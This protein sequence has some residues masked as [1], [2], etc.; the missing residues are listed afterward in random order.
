MDSR[1]NENN[2]NQPSVSGPRPKNCLV[3]FVCDNKKVLIAVLVAVAIYFICCDFGDSDNT[4]F[5]LPGGASNAGPKLTNF[6][7][8]VSS[9][10]DFQFSL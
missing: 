4:T 8:T 6:L 3:K 9:Q 2:N 5:N 1:N 10:S 7:N